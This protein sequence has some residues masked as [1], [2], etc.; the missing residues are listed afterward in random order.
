MD[1]KCLRWRRIVGKTSLG[2]AGTPGQTLPSGGRKMIPLGLTTNRRRLMEMQNLAVM[3]VLKNKVLPKVNYKLLTG[4]GSKHSALYTQLMKKDRGFRSMVSQSG[5]GSGKTDIL[6]EIART[7]RV[8]LLVEKDETAYA[9]FKGKGKFRPYGGKGH[10]YMLD[11]L[12]Y[13]KGKAGGKSKG[14]GKTKSK[15]KGSVNTYASEWNDYYGYGVEFDGAEVMMDLQANT[16]YE[17]PKP[18]SMGK[19]YGMLDTG[20]TCS[21]GPES[22]IKKMKDSKAKVTFDMKKRPRFRFGSGRW[23]RALYK[24][25]MASSLSSATFSA[26]ALPD[27]EEVGEPWFHEGLLVPVLM[28]FIHSHGLI[29]DFND[30]FSVCSKHRNAQ[31]FLL[32]RNEKGH[33]MLNIADFVTNGQSC[34]EGSPEIHVLLDEHMSEEQFRPSFTLPPLIF[35]DEDEGYEVQVTLDASHTEFHELWSRRQHMDDHS[36]RLMGSLLSSR[37]PTTSSTRSLFQ[38]GA[39]EGDQRGLPGSVPGSGSRPEGSSEFGEGAALLRKPSSGE[40]QGQQVGIVDSLQPVQSSLKLHSKS[41]STS[42]GC[43]MPKP[44]ERKVGFDTTTCGV[45]TGHGTQ[46]RLDE[47]DGRQGDCGG[48]HEDA[49]KGVQGPSEEGSYE[50]RQGVKSLGEAFDWAEEFRLRGLERPGTASNDSEVYDK[51]GSSESRSGICYSS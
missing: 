38:H 15:N 27:P 26:Y 25:T 2:M 43:R 45:G 4:R 22:S 51:L 40:C 14:K 19:H 17:A 21:A 16:S 37:D 8:L 39:Q 30:G 34:V 33:Y 32:P 35:E 18:Q 50:D 20:A 9:F 29:V 48:A 6:L 28:D 12:Y 13:M 7:D 47:G 46:R 23:G 36:S 1:L 3:V 41:G 31:P 5:K 44:R 10:H 42:F 49:A 24:V 11:E